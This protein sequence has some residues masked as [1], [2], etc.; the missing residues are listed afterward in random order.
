MIVAASAAVAVA[1]V[2]LYVPCRQEV[3]V[4]LNHV[5]CCRCCQEPGNSVHPDHSAASGR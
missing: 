3:D 1:R 4:I 2:V 5:K